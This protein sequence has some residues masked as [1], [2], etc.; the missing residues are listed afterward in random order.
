MPALKNEKEIRAVLLGP[1]GAGKGTQAPQIK[2]RYC[3]CHLATGDM[4]RAAVAA[5]TEIGLKAKEVMEK[6]QLVSDEIVLGLIKE[7]LSRPECKTGFLLDGFPRTIN[8]AE[9]LDEFLE[10]E[11]RPL[12]HVLEFRISDALLVRRIT[13]R[14][15]HQPSGR[16]YH[17]DF[18]PPKKPMT[19]D[20]TGEPLT[21][22]KDDNEE[23]LKARLAAFHKQTTPLVDFYSKKG[24]H[25]SVDAAQSPDKV[26][27]DIIKLFGSPGK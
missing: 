8:Q 7:N 14:L 23:T 13:G 16:T 12:N 4:L 22:R 19:D 21:R 27:Q 10:K 15:I 1:P 11:G 6:G 5:K 18:N 2:E 26:W 25:E 9:K 24:I 20:V 17:V 3:A